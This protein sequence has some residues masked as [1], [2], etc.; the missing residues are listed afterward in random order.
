[1]LI[2][3]HCHQPLLNVLNQHPHWG[4]FWEFDDEGFFHLRVG[5]WTL[6]MTSTKEHRAAVKGGAFKK[7]DTQTFFAENF[8]PAKRVAQMDAKGVDK[9]V[10]SHPSHW[11]MYW[12]EHDFAVRYASLVN[13]ELARFCSAFPE[14][15]YWWAHLP[16]Q[17]PTACVREAERAIRMGARG[18]GIGGANFGGLELDDHTYYPLWEKACE[19]NVPFF[20]HGYNQSGSWGDKADTEKYDVTAIVGMPYDETRCF[21]NLV[22]GGVLDDFPNLRIYITHGGGYVPYQLG[23]LEGTNHNLS[24]KKNKK[25]VSEYL[26][27]FYFDPL[28]HALPMRRAIVDVIGAD[29]LLYGDNFG[30]MDGVR[31]D[32]TAGIGLSETD[33]EKI[34]WRNASKL[35]K[36]DVKADA[37][38]V[39]RVA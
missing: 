17:N 13:D 3:L 33:R 27:N 36:I 1:M 16:M 8:T 22:C 20:V 4:P 35:L 7:M 23:R 19:L 6:G 12:T 2:N 37:D 30:G 21:W 9:L 39:G 31:D 38:A 24:D 18:F 5:K 28:V 25:L 26:E 10:I 15:L 29:H 14:R 32:L 34:R 11:Y